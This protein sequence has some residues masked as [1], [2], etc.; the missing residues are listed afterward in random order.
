[1]RSG[2]LFIAS[3][4]VFTIALLSSPSH[5]RADEEAPAAAPPLPAY[6]S[7]TNADPAKPL[8]P[9]QTGAASGAWA[10]PAGDS[11]GDTPATL[12]LPDVYDRVAHNLFSINFVWTL[13]TGFLV[14]FM[15]AGF[16]YVETGLCRAKNAAHT[17]A[18]NFMIYPLGC[19][20]FWAY[21]FA[22]GWG[23][24]FNGPVPPGWY[25]SLGPGLAVLNGGIGLG[26]AVDA[27]GNATGAY[28][29]GLMGTKGFFLSSSV[30]DVGVLALFF[31][32]MVFMDTTATIPTGAMAERWSWKNFCLY[33]LWV[34]LP[35]C[36]YANWLWGGGFLAQGGV[37]WGLGH[38]AVDFAGSGV[39][40]GMGGI[41]GLAGAMV[42]GPRI[43]KYSQG[44]P[45]ALPGHDIPMVV[46]GTFILAFGWF[47][48]N[49]GS[50]LA[51]TDLRIS[52]I[53]VNTML[54]SITAAIGAM[55]T[56]QVK[57]LKPDPTMLCN[58]MLAGLV[59]ITAPCAFVDPWAAALIGL[60]AGV[61]VVVSVFFWEARGV[62]DVVG[63][64]SVHGVGG[65]W[66]VLS[67]GIFST[68]QYGAGWN[69]VVRDAFVKEY[70]ADGVRGLLYGDFSQFV[71]QFIDCVVLVVFGFVMA[72]AWFKI[73][74]LI[75]PIRVSAE[76][77][78]E[79][80]DGPEMGAIAYPDFAVHGGTKK[81]IG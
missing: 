81:V 8:W 49:P 1:M 64:I 24:W 17:S 61:L 66:G 43:G 42:I 15:Q 53:V 3:I 7:G 39:V 35:Y 40:H 32:M 30:G 25:A 2:R 50:S 79:G 20:G 77:E 10:A 46:L 70:G 23:N 5:V 44:K 37:N 28:T 55:L 34:A 48:F 58:G 9:D 60:I 13:V 62:D 14:M 75:T 33:G 78:M 11:K 80:L 4:C 54:A 65:L 16:M 74:D 26:A 19:L 76:T 68:G 71:M 57:G 18:M 38:G 21:G 41:I 27:A 69:G 51:G 67:V 12:S 63:A 56:L 29:Y 73:S 52:Y 31:F 36:I 6:F 47:G 45:Q 59:A 72:Y 22:L